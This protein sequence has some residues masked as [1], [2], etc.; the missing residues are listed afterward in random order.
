MYTPRKI[1]SKPGW[2]D[3][4]GVKIYTISFSGRAVD[5]TPFHERLDHVKSGR[6]IDWQNT[7]A[8]AIFHE[9]ANCHYLVL[10]WWGNDNELF[11]SV[12]AKYGDSWQEDPAH[13]SFCLYDMEIMWAERNIY[14]KTI[15]CENP[16]LHAYRTTRGFERSSSE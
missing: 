9:G 13:Y 6:A 11:T 15:D 12:S 16:S 5:Q 4:T 7:A 1:E 3:E 2:M 8:F 10:A 14:I